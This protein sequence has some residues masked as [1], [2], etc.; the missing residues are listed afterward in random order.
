MYVVTLDFHG[1]SGYTKRVGL[2]S[3]LDVVI[4]ALGDLAG[5]MMKWTQKLVC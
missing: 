3:Q 1:S 2:A 4:I 5:I